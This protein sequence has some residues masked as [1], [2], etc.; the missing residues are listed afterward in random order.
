MSTRSGSRRQAGFS[1]LELLVGLGLAAVVFAV[2][3]SFFT[4][5]GRSSTQQNAAAGAQQN[6]RAGVDFV[7]RELR[8]AGL[9]PFQNSGAGIED[10][11]STGTRIRFTADFCNKPIGNSCGAQ[12]EPDGSVE[13]AGERITYL[14]DA[15]QRELRR[16]LY[17]GTPSQATTVLVSRVVP[18]PD[19][20][21]L[22]T[23]V[24]GNGNEVT[25][26]ANRGLIRAVVVTLTVEEPAGRGGTVSRTY[27]SRVRLRN[28]GI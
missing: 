28:I 7:V 2:L 25:D 1:L 4:D 3:V 11:S 26:N 10:I 19:N 15:G 27:C 18:N 8:L 20:V 22:F 6:A 23:F 12:P 17:E 21:N 14:Y 13:G 9:D 24:D 16:V 5:F